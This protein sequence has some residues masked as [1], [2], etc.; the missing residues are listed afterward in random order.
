MIRFSVMSTETNWETLLADQQY[1]A[2][3]RVYSLQPDRDIDFQRNLDAMADI[4]DLQ[5]DR[6]YTRAIERVERIEVLA[7]QFQWD[8]IRE[9]IELLKDV[10]TLIDK[11]DIDEAVDLLGTPDGRY[12]MAEA[13]TL[14]GTALIFQEQSD[15][16][17]AAFERAIAIDSRHYRAITNLGNIALERGETDQ[18]IEHYQRAIELNDSF[19]NAYHNLGVAY[20]KKR[21]IGKSVQALKKAQRF[22]Q[23]HDQAEARE[24]LGKMT[25]SK[26]FGKYLKWLAYGVII[27]GV[28]WIISSQL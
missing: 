3:A 18:A 17:E 10:S 25:G 15:D 22:S 13:L 28:Y 8:A 1:H 5:R 12:F 26:N 4:V 24:Q 6:L 27:F 21:Q 23:K 11:R 14:F 9:E 7:E 20:R 2:A 19:P 16:A